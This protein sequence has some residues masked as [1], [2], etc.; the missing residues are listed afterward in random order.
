MTLLTSSL[1]I[2]LYQVG[3]RVRARVMDRISKVDVIHSRVRRAGVK[4]VT[5]LPCSGVL[6]VRE[7]IRSSE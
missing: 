1:L 2:S 7:M 4:G 6:V 3:V 5:P